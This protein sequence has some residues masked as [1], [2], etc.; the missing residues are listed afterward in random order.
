MAA[1]IA[2]SSLTL[3]CSGPS[4]SSKAA[5]CSSAAAIAALDAVTA[6]AAS[7]E[8]ACNSVTWPLAVW[9]C[10]EL[11]QPKTPAPINPS[12]NKTSTMVL[13]TDITYCKFNKHARR[14]MPYQALPG[15]NGLGH[16][17]KHR[18]ENQ[19]HE[20]SADWPQTDRVCILL[21]ASKRKPTACSI[22]NHQR[23]T[24]CFAFDEGWGDEGNTVQNSGVC[25][26]GAR[27]PGL[28]WDIDRCRE[29]RGIYSG[30]AN[31]LDVTEAAAKRDRRSEPL[32]KLQSYRLV[33]RRIEV[34]GPSA[35]PSAADVCQGG[36]R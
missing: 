1:L 10:F 22:N 34:V 21:V 31:E 13:F 36:R 32:V 33:H 30:S 26:R 35:I 16:I 25:P 17:P 29:I 15:S 24:S 7:S 19:K 23:Q 11:S 4:C 2:S 28:G 9:A 8:A 5:V 18:Y 12:A 27:A 3:F 20:G 6:L 14:L